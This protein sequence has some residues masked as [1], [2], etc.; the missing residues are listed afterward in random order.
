MQGNDSST[1]PSS[2]YGTTKQVVRLTHGNILM[3]VQPRDIEKWLIDNLKEIIPQDMQSMYIN[4]NNIL[5]AYQKDALRE[6]EIEPREKWLYNLTNG[7]RRTILSSFDISAPYT[8][9]V[10]N[11]MEEARKRVA[12]DYKTDPSFL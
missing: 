8:K 6:D 11:R 7:G 1:A 5:F 10:N 2:S 3:S 12:L 4:K 9:I